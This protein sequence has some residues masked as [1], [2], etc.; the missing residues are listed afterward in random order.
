MPFFF[1]EKTIFPSPLAQGQTRHHI[2]FLN[3]NILDLRTGRP[4]GLENLLSSRIVERAGLKIGLIG[5]IDIQSLSQKQQKQLNGVY[6]QD[7]VAAFLKLKKDLHARGAQV[8]VLLG[9]IPSQC[10]SR[11]LYE[12][13]HGHHIPILQCPPQD[14]LKQFVERLPANSLDLIILSGG[15]PFSGRIGELLI[16]NGPGNGHYL[17][18]V[19]LF[20]HRG[21]KRIVFERNQLHPLIKNLSPIFCFHAGLLYPPPQLRTLQRPPKNHARQRL[22]VGSRP[23]FRP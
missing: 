11:P 15:R 21:Q 13:K 3:S 8:L 23:L 19:S 10:E 5:L 22:L 16:L 12:N 9:H 17:G 1:R 4:I 20:Y 2:P 6:F 18:Q 14:P 7:L